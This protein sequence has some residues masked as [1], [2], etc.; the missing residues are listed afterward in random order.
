[1]RRVSPL[2]LL[3]L[4]TTTVVAESAC[5]PVEDSSYTPSSKK[6]KTTNPNGDD[7][8]DTEATDPTNPAGDDTTPMQPG[9]DAGST[10]V[11][12]NGTRGTGGPVG[13]S[14]QTSSSGLSYMIDAPAPGTKPRGVLVLLHGSGASNYTKMVSMMSAVAQ[15]Y[16]LI[17][18]SVL[19]PNG[20]GWNEGNQALGVDKLHQLVQQDLF[21]KYNIDKT[22][23]LFSGQSSGAGFLSS[24]FVPAHAKDYRGG[25]FLQCGAGA[26]PASFAPD[27]S[28]KAGF[29]MHFEITTGDTIWPRQYG[30]ATTNYASLGMQLTK[31][32]TKTGGHCAFDQQAVIQAHIGFVLGATR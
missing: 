17:R 30:E 21:T 28:T 16:D 14:T 23:V 22:K 27:A 6:R 31:D 3:A 32:N 20:Q 10:M 11:Q 8:D 2:L 9:T 26:P 24:M 7:T 19:A 4:F 5:A 13:A 12:D 18:V 1:M 15:T 25:A 29:K